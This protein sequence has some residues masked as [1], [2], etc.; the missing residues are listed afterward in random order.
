MDIPMVKPERPCWAVYEHPV[1]NEKGRQLRPGVYWH[2]FKETAADVREATGDRGDRRI[3]DEW[4]ATPITVIARTINS[5]NGSA[6]RLLRLLTESGPKEWIIAMEVFGGSGEEARRALFAMG[7][8]IALKKR[9]AFM[10]YLLDQHPSKVI[11]T[12]S[13]LGWHESGAFVLPDRT[14]G[15][16]NV[17]YQAGQ[18]A[19][20]PFSSH[21]ELVIW[22]HDVAAKCAGNPVLTLAVSIALAGPLLSLLS[23]LGGGVHL[24]GGSSSGKTL[25]QLIGA[26]I[27]GN[28]KAFTVNWNVTPG[29]LEIAASDRN[30]TFLPLDEISQADA[31]QIQEMVYSLANGHGK[32]TMTRERAGRA[33]LSW[34]LL[35]LSSGEKSLSEHAAISGSSTNAGAELRLVDVNAGARKY[36]AFDELHGLEGAE[37]HRCLTVSVESHYGHL[38]PAFIE[39]LYGL[40]RFELLKEFADLRASFITDN[41]QAGR[42]ADRFAVIAFAGEKAISFGL[43]PWPT[44]S[45]LADCHQLYGEWL[46]EAGKS[47]AENRKVLNGIQD[48]IDRHGSSRFSALEDKNPDNR[49]IN[50]A[51]YWQQV[52]DNRHY[53]FYKSALIEAA[54]QHNLPRI[55]EALEGAKALAL[56]DNGRNTKNYRVA[57]GEQVRLYVVNPSALYP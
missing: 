37:F 46:C 38:G 27:W 54:G 16:S 51:G 34:R 10:Q 1:I 32:S 4:I 35:T 15:N 11:A 6:G 17:R 20:L 52:G 47:D 5:D 39:M 25:A 30:D 50:R 3:S 8:I 12:T 28:P 9:G 48:F 41:A 45:A 7:A 18:N 23:I 26:S 21:G 57:G 36:R 53:L 55:I 44:G 29:G 24:V 2:S 13:R 40:D 33:R 22:Q 49:V 31:Y 14:I 42:V 43:L 19:Q 56:R